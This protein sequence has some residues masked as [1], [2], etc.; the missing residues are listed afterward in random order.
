M[1]RLAFDGWGVA[2][3]YIFFVFLT[4][5]LKGQGSNAYMLSAPETQK[6]HTGLSSLLWTKV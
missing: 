1:D 5:T 4:E 2:K 3:C 6:A